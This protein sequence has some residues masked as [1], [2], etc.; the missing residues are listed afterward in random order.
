VTLTPTPEQDELRARLTAEAI[1]DPT[2]GCWLPPPGRRGPRREDHGRYRHIWI[3]G[4]KRRRH[5]VSFEA[6]HGPVP[7]GHEVCHSCDNPPCFCPEH[8]HSGTHGDNLREMVARGRWRG[9][10]Y[11]RTH[12]KRGHERTPENLY[13]HPSGAKQCRVCRSLG[14]QRWAEANR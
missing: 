4:K 1:I 9:G 12:C 7:D 11:N 10:G 14:W 6:F 3:G 5:V 13:E 2:T 8:L